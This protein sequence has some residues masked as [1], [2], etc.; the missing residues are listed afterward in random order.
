ML[1]TKGIRVGEDRAL[2]ISLLAIVSVA[3]VEIV[4]GLM[5]NVMV[6]IADGLH[7]TSDALLTLLLLLMLRW[8]KKPRDQ[9]HTYGHG[10]IE[11]IAGLVGGVILSIVAVLIIRESIVR[12]LEGEYETPTIIVFY[13]VII[14]VVVAIFRAVIL[15][16]S[17][18]RS[19]SVRAGFYDALSDLGSS[20]LALVSLI[21]T[22]YSIYIADGLASIVLAGM[23]IFLTSRLAYSSALELSD[24]I[25]PRLVARARDAVSRVEGVREC[26]DLRMRKVGND[27][28]VDVTIVLESDITF[29][30]AHMISS[31]VENVVM[32]AVNATTVMVHFE[33]EYSTKLE[34]IIG[35]AILGVRGVRNMHNLIVSRRGSSITV[36]VHIQVDKDLTLEKADEVVESVEHAIRS[37][38]CSN[39]TT[40]DNVTVHLEPFINTV[41]DVSEAKDINTLEDIVR[42]I[43]Y[44]EG[45]KSI[46]RIDAYLCKDRLMLDIHCSLDADMSIEEAHKMIS[47]IESKLSDMLDARVTIHYR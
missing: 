11:S 10:R 39:D 21:L 7:A 47:N 24:A 16:G 17:I 44:M 36:S 6:V 40:V 28:L 23:I 37:S 4:T 13:V 45:V 41:Q 1:R 2:L 33:P 35:D 30:K 25:D 14:A 20:T 43:A 27:L 8:S 42:R 3:I 18:H 26:R 15:K 32:K 5:S 19:K 31:E 34:H 9:E 38:I 46:E 22:T 29:N 12:I